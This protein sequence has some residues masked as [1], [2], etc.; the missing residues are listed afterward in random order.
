MAKKMVVG[1]YKTGDLNS[2]LVY[3]TPIHPPTNWPK[4]VGKEYIFVK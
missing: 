2:P 1:R 4:E 3:V